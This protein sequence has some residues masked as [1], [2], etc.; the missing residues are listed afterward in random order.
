MNIQSNQN[1]IVQNSSAIKKDVDSYFHSQR[2]HSEFDNGASFSEQLN[3][4]RGNIEFIVHLFNAEH[5]RIIF[6]E[7][8]KK[9][10]R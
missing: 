6:R 9:L 3:F 8:K 4:A 2:S 1:Q 5:T 7:I 10:E